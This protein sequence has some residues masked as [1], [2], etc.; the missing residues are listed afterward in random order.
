MNCQDT[1]NRP[2]CVD[3]P[4]ED[5]LSF[6][7]LISKMKSLVSNSNKPRRQELRSSEHTYAQPRQA[8]LTQTGLVRFA[9]S[10]ADRR[11]LKL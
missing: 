7:S 8:L 1:H 10:S 3:D 9:G 4:W 5:N 6:N 11:K 2:C